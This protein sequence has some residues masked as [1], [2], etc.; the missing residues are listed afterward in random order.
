MIGEGLLAWLGLGVLVAPLR[1]HFPELGATFERAILRGWQSQGDAAA[2][3]AAAREFDEAIGFF[4]RLVLQ[5]LVGLLDRATG[6]G[7]R[8]AELA[9]G[10]LRG[11]RLFQRCRGLEGWLVE[12]LSKLRA[13]LGKTETGR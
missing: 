5:A 10:P 12:N 8:G 13:P 9:W 11:S 4:V 6:Q 1:E 2:L 7:S 3:E